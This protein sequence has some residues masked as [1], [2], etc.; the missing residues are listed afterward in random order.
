MKDLSHTKI[1]SSPSLNNNW[2]WFIRIGLFQA[3]KKGAKN[4]YTYLIWL[5][6]LV[7]NWRKNKYPNQFIMSW[8]LAGEESY[9]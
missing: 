7:I 9:A 3:I 6:Y 1:T 5:S 2:K 4:I 8:A